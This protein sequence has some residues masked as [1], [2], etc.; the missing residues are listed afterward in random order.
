MPACA[1]FH[2][3]NGRSRL[4]PIKHLHSIPTLVTE[5]VPYS[6]MPLQLDLVHFRWLLFQ[7]AKI[8]PQLQAAVLHL[9]TTS[10]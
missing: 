5:V 9:F 1:R 8:L 10:I 4:A 2:G 7:S 6:A 3:L